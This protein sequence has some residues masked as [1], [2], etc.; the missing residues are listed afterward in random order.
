MLERHIWEVRSVTPY[1]FIR[2]QQT[3]YFPLHGRSNNDRRFHVCMI[4]KSQLIAPSLKLAEPLVW[5]HATSAKIQREL[6]YMH[7]TIHKCDA[8]CLMV[9]SFTCSTALG[10]IYHHVPWQDTTNP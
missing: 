1:G 8:I 6:P 4:V 9:Q 3:I 10:L 2:E 5:H 7:F